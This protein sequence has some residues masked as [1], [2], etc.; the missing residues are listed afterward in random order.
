M[1]AAA[2]R[3]CQRDGLL[4]TYT[5]VLVGDVKATCREYRTFILAVSRLLKLEMIVSALSAVA[6]AKIR[7][8]LVS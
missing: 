3:H 6:L 4:H 2:P 1:N 5:D 7:E 8:R